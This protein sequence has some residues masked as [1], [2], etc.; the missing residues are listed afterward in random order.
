MG[1]AFLII[2]V[3][4]GKLPFEQIKRK[5]L[6]RAEEEST[7]YGHAPES[8]TTNH[9]LQT[10][11]VN[12]DKPAGPTSTQ[13]SDFVKNILYAKK[14]G[15]SGTLDPNVTGVFPV[16]IDN[17]TKVLHALLTAGKEYVALMHLHE[18]VPEKKLHE[19]LKEFTGKIYQTPPTK[20]AVKRSLRIREV[21]YIDVL[22]ISGKDV[23]FKIGCES[24]TYIRRFCF[25]IGMA[26]GCG[27][28]MQQLR[29]TKLACFDESHMVTLQDLA[30]A[31][32]FWK[33]EKNE[34]E[35]RKVLQPMENA[36][37]HLPKII[38]SDYAV[39]SLC[40]GAQL[41]IPGIL[42]ISSEI[43]SGETIAVFT[44]KDEGVIIGK[45]LKSSEE[46]LEEE[47]GIAVKTERVLMEPG[48]YPKYRE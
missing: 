42:K 34:K 33:E 13:V 4:M 37:A 40:H 41:A 2:L 7:E 15:H 5:L 22:E 26:I 9:L 39:D 23:L 8:R 43:K 11:V 27:A 12:I 45:A 31:Y 28:H 17:G 16:G 36:L 32:Y 38:I 20:S 19:V 46:I 47:K 10:G 48:V 35:L 3:V 25:D 24:G 18:K 14:A 1:C 44:Q 29:R 21:Y 6:V 30:D